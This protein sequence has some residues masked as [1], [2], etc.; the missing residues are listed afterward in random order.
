MTQAWFMIPHFFEATCFNIVTWFT[1]CQTQQI[2]LYFL[3]LWFPFVYLSPG[4]RFNVLQAFSSSKMVDSLVARGSKER[5]HAISPNQAAE[6]LNSCSQPP[7]CVQNPLF[8]G[9]LFRPKVG[10]VVSRFRVQALEF[11]LETISRQ[12]H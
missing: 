6:E 1:H 4:D 2:V 11:K 7:N 3:F 10:H 5:C 12:S 8:L 9:G